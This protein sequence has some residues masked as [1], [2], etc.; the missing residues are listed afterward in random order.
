M[1]RCSSGSS[2]TERGVVGAAEDIGTGIDRGSP[3][4]DS[5]AAR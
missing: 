5:P 1:T 4:L 3:S 2:R